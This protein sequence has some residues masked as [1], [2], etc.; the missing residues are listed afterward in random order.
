M[1]CSVVRMCFT[2]V[3]VG[4]LTA[5]SASSDPA[6]PGSPMNISAT[7][8]NAPSNDSPVPSQ[9]ANSQAEASVKRL[10][11]KHHLVECEGYQV[12]H[13]L[14]TQEGDSLE[15]TYFYD[16]ID[17]FDYQWGYDYE[18]LVAVTDEAPGLL[19]AP[20]PRYTLVEVLSE[21]KHDVSEVFHYTSRRSHER[22]IEQDD[23]SFSLLG[24]KAFTCDTDDCES[25]RAAIAQ[26]QSAVLSFFHNEN[27]TQPLLLESVLCSDAAQSFSDS[28][29]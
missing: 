24:K 14:L 19:S 28:C 25:V 17:G 11:V 6:P 8:Q 7:A 16:E 3:V 10:R 1:G 9:S 13:C 22:I 4:G 5:C 18:L 15:W 20:S 26:N 12:D 23:G 21:A 29:L 27:P 2:V